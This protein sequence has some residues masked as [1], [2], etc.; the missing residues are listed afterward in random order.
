MVCIGNT[1]KILMKKRILVS[2]LNWG[3]GHAT[4]CIPIINALINFGFEPIIASDGDALLLLKKEFPSLLFMEFPSYKI[5]YPKD[6]KYF[7]LHLI[8]YAP[9]IL[10]AIYNEKKITANLIKTYNI[11]GIISDNRLGVYNKK[12]P[13][14]FITHQLQVLSGSTT[15]LSTLIHKKFINSFNECW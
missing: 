8:K 6:K 15:W 3:I 13:S 2:P 4:R 7:K 12:V 11:E 14:I 5:S 9:K 1:T 10:K